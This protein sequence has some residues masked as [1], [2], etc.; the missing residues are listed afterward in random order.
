M[1]LRT[2]DHAQ[3]WV[4]M[5]LVDRLLN[6]EVFCQISLSTPNAQGGTYLVDKEVVGERSSLQNL[7]LSMEGL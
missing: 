6:K 3:M 5:Y 7:F 4:M 1:W 2:S